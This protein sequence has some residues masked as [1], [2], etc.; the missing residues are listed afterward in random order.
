MVNVKCA[1]MRRK[2]LC[3]TNK[4][5]YHTAAVAMPLYINLKKI[6]L[7]VDKNEYNYFVRHV[8]MNIGSV[9]LE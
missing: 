3:C 9:V 4:L 5:P 2:N 7:K 1:G 8:A 6:R